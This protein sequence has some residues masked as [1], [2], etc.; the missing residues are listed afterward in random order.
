MKNWGTL[1]SHQHSICAPRE[2]RHRI[3]N[4]A[5]PTE[6]IIIIII[7]HNRTIFPSLL[8]LL[9]QSHSGSSYLEFQRLLLSC[10][11]LRPW[12]M[13][14]RMYMI[15]NRTLALQWTS[16]APYL[17]WCDATTIL[18]ASSAIQFPPFIPQNLIQ[19]GMHVDGLA[20]NQ[21][22][23]LDIIIIILRNVHYYYGTQ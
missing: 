10:Y 17:C 8:W 19:C 6:C 15:A 13:P 12:P 18:L 22:N 1:S 16:L 23:N 7:I 14:C 5:E 21:Q 9:A 4:R 20:H 2:N 3:L 11:T